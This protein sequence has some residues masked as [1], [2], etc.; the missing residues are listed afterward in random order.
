MRQFAAAFDVLSTGHVRRAAA[1]A[2]AAGRR[3]LGGRPRARLERIARRVIPR[4]ALAYWVVQMLCLWDL[5]VLAALEDWQAAGRQHLRGW[6]EA[7]G[8]I[9]ALAALAAL[10]HAHPDWAIPD[11][12]PGCPG[13]KPGRRA[14]RCSRA[15]TR[16]DNDIS[17]GPPGTFLLVTGSNMAGKSTYLRTIGTNI[18]LAQ[19][20]GPVCAREFRMPPLDLCTS[21]RV[22]DSLE[23]GVSTFFAEVMRLKQV[24][25]VVRSRE[26]SGG[27]CATCS[28]RSCRAPTPP[29]ARSPCVG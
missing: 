17:L 5:H 9:E 20:G 14:T 13:W 19:A 27:R 2:R 29:S 24:V 3:S 4:S 28:T 25:D 21:M 12:E 15:D 1:G 10:A 11:V 16:V 18:V 8:E 6:L 26:R 7:L 22:V 23:R